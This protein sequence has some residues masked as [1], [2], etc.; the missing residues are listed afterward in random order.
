MTYT[1]P[2]LR[3]RLCVA[4]FIA[5]WLVPLVW[6]G[7]VSPARLPGEPAIFHRWHS[8]SCLFTD[9]PN[10]RNTYYVQVRYFGQSE[11][12]T[13]D[14]AGYFEMEPFG[15]RTRMHRYLVRW[16]GKK[17]RGREELAAWLYRR[18]AEL[19]PDRELPSELRFVH[20]WTIPSVDEPPTGDAR[21]P[22]LSEF[23]EERTQI[24]SLHAPPPELADAHH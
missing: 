10:Q 3:D 14:L 12:E 9:R 24:M 5:F 4:G 15:Y 6:H 11:W 22:P 7:F 19:H 23:P 17:S 21:P 2:R 20:A 18:H 8:I 16:R 13:L 1:L